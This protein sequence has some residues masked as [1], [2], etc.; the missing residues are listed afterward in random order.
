[1]R[2]ADEVMAW[3]FLGPP[4]KV[5]GFTRLTRLHINGMR[6]L[7]LDGDT[8]NCAADNLM[9]VADEGYFAALRFGGIEYEMQHSLAPPATRTKRGGL[10]PMPTARPRAVRQ[11]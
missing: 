10:R 9:W 4:P 5:A 7:H 6:V 1:M 2:F 11:L 8:T 3:T